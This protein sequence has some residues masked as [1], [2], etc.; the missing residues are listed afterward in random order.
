MPFI[1]MMVTM[2]KIMNQMLGGSNSLGGLNTLPYSPAFMPGMT[3]GMAGLSALNSFPMSPTGMN[4][5]PLTGV[6]PMMNNFQTG[7]SGSNTNNSNNFWNPDTQSVSS[8]GRATNNGLNGIWQTLSGDVIAVYNDNR[9][10]WSDG[11]SRNLSGHLSV[12]GNKM[13]AYVPS[14]NITMSFQFYMEPGQFVVRDQ[15]GRIYTFKRIH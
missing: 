9:F 8:V 14:K 3:N 2:M 1:E 15:S 6:S 5:L 12:K 7:Q 4:S 11:G 10:L 13:I